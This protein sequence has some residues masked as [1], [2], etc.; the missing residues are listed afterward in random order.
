[1]DF[2]ENKAIKY[3]KSHSNHEA[4]NAYSD[5]DILLVIDAIFDYF[6]K[7]DESEDFDDDIKK[8]SNFVKQQL[9][10]DKFNVVSPEHV[11]PIVEAELAY[12]Q[13]LSED[14]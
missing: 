3:I 1:M 14:Y 7:Y 8:I 11:E 4:I 9:A 6:E 5:D 10:K 12:E 2:D 13:T